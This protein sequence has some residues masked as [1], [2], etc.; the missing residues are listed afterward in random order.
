MQS[1]AR[2]RAMKKLLTTASILGLLA[3]PAWAANPP[4][5]GGAA[6]ANPPAAAPT[7]NAPS[8]PAPAPANPPSSQQ[9][10][11]NNG[12]QGSPDSDFVQKAAA[13]GQAEV[14]MGKLAEQQAGTAAVREF[15]RWM[16]TDHTMA[17]NMLAKAAQQANMQAPTSPT[18]EQQDNLN[19]LKKL[20]GAAFD[21]SYMSMM[22]KD[23]TEDVDLFRNE[24]QSGQ[25][26][27]I[28]TFAQDTLPVLEA[29]LTEAKELSGGASASTHKAAPSTARLNEHELKRHERTKTE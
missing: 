10:A 11:A 23:H 15:G 14:D 16:V 20:H 18:Q 13:G 28:K 9:G 5:S 25:N 24:A 17:N 26:D 6:P 1:D 3:A 12:Q 4:P 29:H 2:E 22:V 19:K 21:R 8:P 7:T 27:Q